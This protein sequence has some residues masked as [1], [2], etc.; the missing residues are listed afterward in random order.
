M[1]ELLRHGLSNRGIGH[2]LDITARTAKAHVASIM[3]KLSAKD[4]AEAVAWG[5]ELGLLRT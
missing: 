1:L 3:L 2:R 5:F 4:R